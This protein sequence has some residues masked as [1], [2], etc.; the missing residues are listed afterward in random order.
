[1]GPLP[2]CA[3]DTLAQCFLLDRTKRAPED[4]RQLRG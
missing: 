1:M 2:S 3:A 4:W